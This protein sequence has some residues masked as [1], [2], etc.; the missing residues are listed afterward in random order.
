MISAS[1]TEAQRLGFVRSTFPVF[2]GRR[3]KRGDDDQKEG[4]PVT[5]LMALAAALVAAVAMAM[6]A[7]VMSAPAIPHAD[8]G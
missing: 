2:M 6:A 1:K 7:F 8:I 4:D 5:N 3:D